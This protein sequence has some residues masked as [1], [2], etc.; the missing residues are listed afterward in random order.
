MMAI[1]AI[2]N[3]MRDDEFLASASFRLFADL[4]D[5]APKIIMMPV[6]KRPDGCGPCPLIRVKTP[7][8]RAIDEPMCFLIFPFPPSPEY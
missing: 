5:S 2:S 8:T 4:K 7:R 3:P 1:A 6:I